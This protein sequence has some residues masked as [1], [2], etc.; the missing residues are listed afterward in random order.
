MGVAENALTPAIGVYPNP[1]EG[2]FT[3]SVSGSRVSDLNIQ[4]ANIQG[5]VVYRNEVKGAISHEEKIDLTRFAKGMYFLKVNNEVIK[6][7]VK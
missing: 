4:V 5:Q 3:L 2:V 6:L 7:V 1:T